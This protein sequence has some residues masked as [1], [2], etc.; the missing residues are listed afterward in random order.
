MIKLALKLVSHKLSAMFSD[1]KWLLKLCN[2][3]K[4]NVYFNLL[5]SNF[6]GLQSVCNEDV[7]SKIKVWK[8]QFRDLVN[9]RVRKLYVKGQKFKELATELLYAIT[10]ESYSN[11]KKYQ[12][13]QLL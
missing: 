6:N 12:N 2:A 5:G 13:Y 4:P 10:P 3:Y 1:G 11:A 7:L 8:F 9:Q